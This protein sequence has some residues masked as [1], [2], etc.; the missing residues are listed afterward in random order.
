MQVHYR[1]QGPLPANTYTFTTAGPRFKVD[2]GTCQQNI[3]AV[4]S[5]LHNAAGRFAAC[6]S[7]QDRASPWC[8]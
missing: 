1:G 8:Y 5:S 7:R 6:G 2:I 3:A 4:G